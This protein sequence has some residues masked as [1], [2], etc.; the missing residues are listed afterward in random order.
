MP[1]ILYDDAGQ[2]TGLC[3]VAQYPGH[4]YYG[5]DHPDVRAYRQMVAQMEAQREQR[6]VQKRQRI[7]ALKQSANA[8]VAEL[9]ALLENGL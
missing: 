4:K 2:P 8:E 9:A 7:M 3:E 1:Y 5:E 6:R